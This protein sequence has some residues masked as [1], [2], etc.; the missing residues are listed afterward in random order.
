[1]NTRARLLH[2]VKDR[3]DIPVLP[4]SVEKHWAVGSVRENGFAE[5]AE[6]CL[7]N[8]EDCELYSH[9]IRQTAFAYEIAVWDVVGK[10]VNGSAIDAHGLE[11]A[12]RQYYRLRRLTPFAGENPEGR[13]IYLLGTAAAGV[14][15]GE[16]TAVREWQK[17]SPPEWNMPEPV[18][19]M[20]ELVHGLVARWRRLVRGEGN[21]LAEVA[22]STREIRKGQRKREREM[23]E[24]APCEDRENLGMKLAGFYHAIEATNRL[25]RAVS[26]GGAADGV[27]IDLHFALA[28]KGMGQ[29]RGIYGEGW[30]ATVRWLTAAAG[31]MR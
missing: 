13:A 30:Q 10:T 19:W 2:S 17:Q 31:V 14:C 29:Y 24:A 21:G 9:A 8:A 25:G 5:M 28:A 11:P 4:E 26:E 22:P 18:T 1:M 6:R 7:A 16:L 3:A 27:E 12:C 23:L 20:E 15:A